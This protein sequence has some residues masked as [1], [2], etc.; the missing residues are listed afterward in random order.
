MP[1][2]KEKKAEEVQTKKKRKKKYTK[3]VF[4]NIQKAALPSLKKE[5]H[6]EVLKEAVERFHYI[7]T[8]ASILFNTH[9]KRVLNKDIPFPPLEK[10]YVVK[11]FYACTMSNNMVLTGKKE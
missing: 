10:S 6:L 7:R 5:E 11:F 1:K 4:V 3:P 2:R 9:M 8:I